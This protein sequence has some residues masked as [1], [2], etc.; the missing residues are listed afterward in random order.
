MRF[1]K[2][3]TFVVVAISLAACATPRTADNITLARVARDTI[4]VASIDEIT[5]SNVQKSSTKDDV[6]GRTHY[7]YFVDT[8]RGKKFICDVDLAGVDPGGKLIGNDHVICDNR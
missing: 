6:L 8:V 2:S 3:A 5:I 7:R 4:G 1:F